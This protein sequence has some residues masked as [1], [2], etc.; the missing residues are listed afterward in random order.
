MVK[1]SVIIVSYNVKYFLEQALQSVQKALEGMAGEVWV[2]DNDSDDDSAGLVRKRFPKVHLIA[3]EKNEG[4]A[5][6]NN[7]ALNQCNGE[8]V[9]LLNPDTV[10]EE[11]TFKKVVTFMDEHPEAGGVG[12]KMLD[13]KGNFLKES[14]RG[15][16]S[17][18]VAFF[19]AFGFASLFPRSAVF[20]R[21]YLG[22]LS[23]E[24]TQEVEVLAGA[25][26]LIRKKVLDE[27]GLLD[28]TFFMY[29]EDIDLSFRIIQAGYK[30]YYYPH[31]R[32]I[33]YKGESTKK[34]S[35]NYVRMF[36]RAMAIFYKKHFGSS[37]AWLF[38][39]MVHVAI[40]AKA[41]V[42]VLSGIA[43]RFYLLLVDAVLI[44]GGLYAIQHYWETNVKHVPDYYPFEYIAYIMPLYVLFWVVGIFFSGGYDRPFKL[45]KALRGIL[46]GT[47]FIS[48]IYG[49]LNESYRF[50]RAVILLGAM[51]AVLEAIIT[52]FGLHFLKHRNFD[53]EG[54]LKKNLIIV[55]SRQEAER[56]LSLLKQSG[57]DSAYRGLVSPERNIHPEDEHFIG[58][59]DELEDIVEVYEVDEVIFCARDVPAGDII[60]Q[61][62]TI[63]SGKEYK[64]VPEGSLSIIGSNSRNTAG[65]L[66][67]IDVNLSISSPM[68][69]R[70][71]RVFDLMM[72]GLFL[73]ASPGIVW[74]VK[75]RPGFL[76]NW[77]KVLAG[78]KT[79]V[80]YA[81]LA[82][83]QKRLLLPPIKPAVLNPT[84]A[85][86]KNQFANKTIRHLN[87]Q[88]ARDYSAWRDLTI[89]RKNITELG[90]RQ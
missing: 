69:R 27:V 39:I 16:P 63:G 4:F 88:Y 13:G 53:V 3:N 11:D 86:R 73:L 30:N 15:F 43:G 44:Y 22:H 55:G 82:D 64:I 56:V 28:E 6:A 34:G 46:I 62:S 21:Y 48:A 32:I 66:Y 19:K 42:S 84:D 8:Y 76:Q 41:I 79:W 5:K 80:G 24:E 60:R 35:L 77:L 33:H 7:R 59:I 14:K 23:H 90:R 70:N 25:F 10:V 9:L 1:L 85:V 65:E 57:V 38:S 12:V 51:W 49:F 50:S 17:P 31:T 37:K 58:D 71:K 68:S 2:V 47:L 36:Y 45:S 72:C 67:A 26:M 52:R 81:P 29:G 61:I 40:W 75:N 20:A 74:V 78:Q 54:G 89:V 87:L 18:R 83:T